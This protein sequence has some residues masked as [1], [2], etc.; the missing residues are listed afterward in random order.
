MICRTLKTVKVIEANENV[1]DGRRYN[2]KYCKLNT[3]LLL[4]F[5]DPGYF[6]N[7]G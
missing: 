3:L 5:I 7:K 2:P 4:C 6:A 1:D